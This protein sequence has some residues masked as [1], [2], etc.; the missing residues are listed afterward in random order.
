MIG[1]DR[2]GSALIGS[3]LVGGGLMIAA[4]WLAR[5]VAY[6]WQL[7]TGLV[8]ALIG[9]PCLMLLLARRRGAG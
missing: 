2:A 9:A 3:A 7:P 4:D 1:L 6:P 8:A 5:V